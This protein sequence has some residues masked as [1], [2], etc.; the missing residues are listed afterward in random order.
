MK[1]CKRCLY[2][3]AIP[4]ISFNQDGICNYCEQYDS[5]NVQYPTGEAGKKKIE[6]YVVQMKKDGKGKPYDVVIGVSG[7][8]DSSYMLH[9]AK[10]IY[11]LRVLAA[12]FDN[13]Y[14]SKIAVENI[15]IVLDKLDIDL[16]TYVVDNKEFENIQKSLLLASVPEFEAATDLSLA[17]THYMAAAKYGIKHIW[18][19]HSFRT[20]GVSPPGWFYMDAKY[21]KSIHKIFGDGIIKSTPLLWLSKWIKWMVVYKIKKFRPLYY[22]DYNKE[23]VKSFLVKEYGW[24]WYGGHH[25]ENRTSYFINN[26]YLP[27][28]FDIDLRWCEYSA[29]VRSGYLG[30]EDALVKIKE[31]KPYDS[32]L[33]V[34]IK[35]R[36][37]LSDNDWQQI[38]NAPN[39]HYTDYPTYKKTFERMRPLFFTLLK[40]GYVTRSFYD[41]FCVLKEDKKKIKV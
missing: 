41:K 13:T 25:M 35:S 22:L 6:D 7:G 28:K 34:E 18:E 21:I 15:K 23:E 30:R 36:L 4:K 38:M 9:L 20:E 32:D 16:Y 17:T 33:L 29:L 40:A 26:Y 14:N 5:M 37:G 2:N 31:P 10:K 19:G 24:Q 27:V 39:K 1:N 12:H 8:C 3:S 11:G